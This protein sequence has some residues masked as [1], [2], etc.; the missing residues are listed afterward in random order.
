M[1]SKNMVEP[2]PG[3]VYVCMRAHVCVCDTYI[4]ILYI[5]IYHILNWSISMCVYFSGNII[6][7]CT[8]MYI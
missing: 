3:C 8:C 4:S 7:P 2:Y 6:Y 1:K 5:D